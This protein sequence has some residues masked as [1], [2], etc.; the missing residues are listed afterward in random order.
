MKRDRAKFLNILPLQREDIELAEAALFL[1][2]YGALY[3][4]LP[5]T[6]FHWQHNAQRNTPSL[7]YWPWVG[8]TIG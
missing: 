7:H 5:L 6:I 3:V 1:F 4:S 2:W 8:F